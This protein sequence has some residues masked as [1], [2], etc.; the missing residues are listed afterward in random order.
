MQLKYK[1][2]SDKEKENV[3][4]SYKAGKPIRVPLRWCV[5]PRIIILNPELNPGKYTF[6]DY[7]NDPEAMIKVQAIFY[8]YIAI[9][10]SKKLGIVSFDTGFPINHGELRKQLGPD[11]EV[12]GGPEVS[13]L[14]AGTPE[15]CFKKAKEILESGIKEGGKFILQE[16]NNL[17]PCCPP[18]NLAAVY[19]ACLTYGKY[20]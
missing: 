6:E 1:I 14:H 8:E 19:E 17:P 7:F 18:E 4:A 10:L 13:L 9:E 16:G 12:S 15:A 11:V 20:E 2:P 5:N 3:W